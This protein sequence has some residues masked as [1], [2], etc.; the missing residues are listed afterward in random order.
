M[1]LYKLATSTCST[2]RSVLLFRCC[3]RWQQVQYSK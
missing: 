2:E 1:N 3:F